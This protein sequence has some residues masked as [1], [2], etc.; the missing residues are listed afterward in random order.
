[1]N[2]PTHTAPDGADAAAQTDSAPLL[3]RVRDALA[4]LE[5]LNADRTMLDAL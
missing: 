5:Q 2:T 3:D 1:M 4:V